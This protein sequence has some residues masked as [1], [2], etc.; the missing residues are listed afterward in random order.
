MLI[1]EYENMASNVRALY[2]YQYHRWMTE[3]IPRG[4]ASASSDGTDT[5][6]WH[7][8]TFT[9]KTSEARDSRLHIWFNPEKKLKIFLNGL[10]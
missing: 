7:T 1:N 3:A 10:L 4:M 8:G 5:G 2:T 9:H 6:T